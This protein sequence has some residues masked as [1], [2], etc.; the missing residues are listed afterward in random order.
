MEGLNILNGSFFYG[1]RISDNL[2]EGVNSFLDY[3]L[4]LF[5]N[6]FSSY[7]S[8]RILVFHLFRGLYSLFSGS[9]ILLSDLTNDTLRD[10]DNLVRGF[11]FTVS[12][13]NKLTFRINHKNLSTD[14]KLTF[15]R[16]NTLIGSNITDELNEFGPCWSRM[17]N[18]S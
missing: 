15:Q 1:E 14:F 6:F 11:I 10:N 7:F 3:F 18:S 5:D 4:S 12:S 13:R 16:Q 17:P 9:F 8:L 2:I